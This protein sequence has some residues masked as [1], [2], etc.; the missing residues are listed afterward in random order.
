MSSSERGDKSLGNNVL[1]RVVLIFVAG[2]LVLAG[3]QRAINSPVEAQSPSTSL[4]IEPGT[5]IIRAPDTGGT[6]GEGKMVIDLKTGNIWGFPTNVTGSPYP[7]DP[8][9]G[10]P[11]V[12]KPVYLG[13]LD[14]SEMKAP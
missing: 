12:S 4:Y 2:F 7:I 5:I 1:I 3:L 11:A 13:R 9:K 10:K 6:I 8:I 14:F